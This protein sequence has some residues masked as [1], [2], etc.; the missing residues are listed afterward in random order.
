MHMESMDSVKEDIGGKETFWKAL[1][2]GSK[3][4]EC[5]K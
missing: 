4:N 2:E 5:L 3:S 1:L